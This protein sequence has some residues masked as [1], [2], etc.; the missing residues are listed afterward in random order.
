MEARA[1]EYCADKFRIPRLIIK[2]P[3]DRIGEETKNFDKQEACRKLAENLD[4]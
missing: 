1:I 3:Y 4:Y 2:I